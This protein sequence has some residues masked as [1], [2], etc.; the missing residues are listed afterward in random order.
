VAGACRHLFHVEQRR[1]GDPNREDGN[2]GTPA[3]HRRSRLTPT[4][5]GR[6]CRKTVEPLAEILM[7]RR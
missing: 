7:I 5:R 3:D 4:R 1:S 6:F 2:G